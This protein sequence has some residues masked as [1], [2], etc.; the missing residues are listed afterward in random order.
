M[1][2]NM[3][4]LSHLVIQFFWLNVILGSALGGRFNLLLH[5]H[6][7]SIRPLRRQF[8]NLRIVWTRRTLLRMPALQIVRQFKLN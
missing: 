6:N 1:L 5:F 3:S 8:A 4:T 7:F 2:R